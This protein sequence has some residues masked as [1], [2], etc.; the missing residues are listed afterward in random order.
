MSERDLR[1]LLIENIAYQKDRLLRHAQQLK[2]GITEEDILQPF[3]YPELENDP[4]FRY[5]EGILHGLMVAEMALKRALIDHESDHM[6][7]VSS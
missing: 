4:S 7:P 2:S 5:E 1:E 6:T 3:D